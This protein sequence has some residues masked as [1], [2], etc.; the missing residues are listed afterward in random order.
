MVRLLSLKGFVTAVAIT[1]AAAAGVYAW[2]WVHRERAL[3][4]HLRDGHARR[5]RLLQVIADLPG[6]LAETSGL[7]VSRTN[8][9]VVWSHND[10]GNDPVLYALDLTGRLIGNVRVRNAANQDWEDMSAGPCPGPAGEA[11]RQNAGTASCLYIGDIGDNLWRRQELTVYIVEEPVLADGGQPPDAVRS[12]AFRFR[13]SRRPDDSEALAVD[14]Q[15]DVVIVTKGLAGVP[16]FFRISADHVAQ[17]LQSGE[18]LTAVHEMN[19]PVRTDHDVARLVTGA[20]FSPDGR[21][22]AVRTYHEVMFF[23]R[24]TSATVRQWE[25]VGAPCFLG[26]AEP[27]GEAIDYLSENTLL[28]TSERARGRAAHMHRLQC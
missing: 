26:D 5:P 10:S 21:T 28:L 3:E 9:G 27:Q 19:F 16:G 12:R 6:E 18:T 8:P 17:A 7:A 20:A 25:A 24:S 11:A 13:Y 14:E 23:R 1:A 2:W 15:G 22:L 4:A